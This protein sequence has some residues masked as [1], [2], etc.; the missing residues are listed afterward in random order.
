MHMHC[1]HQARVMDLDTLSAIRL[2]A[3]RRYP[4]ARNGIILNPFPLCDG[5]SQ[6]TSPVHCHVVGAVF[7]DSYNTVVLKDLH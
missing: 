2:Q 5:R 1:C 7:A 3:P 4:Y 6:P